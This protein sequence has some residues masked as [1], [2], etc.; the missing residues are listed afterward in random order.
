MSIRVGSKLVTAVVTM[1]LSDED[2]CEEDDDNEDDRDSDTNQDGGV[3]W[4]SGDGLGPGGL[5]ELVHRGVGSDLT[6][7]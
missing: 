7:K 1:K 2:E 4:V 6:K 5:T 3:V